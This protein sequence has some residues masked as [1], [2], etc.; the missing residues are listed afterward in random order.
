MGKKEDLSNYLKSLLHRCVEE[1][2]YEFGTP[3]GTGKSHEIA[4]ASVSY[5]PQKFKQILILTIQ[6]KLSREMEENLMRL[7]DPQNGTITQ[8]Q[9]IYIENNQNNFRRACKDGTAVRLIEQMQALIEAYNQKDKQTLRNWLKNPYTQMSSAYA[10]AMEILNNED[11]IQSNSSMEK[12]K[13]EIVQKAEQEYRKAVKQ[14]FSMIRAQE[15]KSDDTF[16]FIKRMVSRCPA[17]EQVYPQINFHEKKVIVT[18]VHKAYDGIDLIFAPS[19]SLKSF[20]NSKDKRLVIFDES[21]QCATALRQSIIDKSLNRNGFASELGKN[22]DGWLHIIS[23]MKLKDE[24]TMKYYDGEIQKGLECFGKRAE[25][26]WKEKMGDTPKFRNIFLRESE[27]KELLYRHG[28]FMVGGSGNVRLSTQ[29]PTVLSYICYKKGDTFLTLAHAS[30]K[31]EL[32]DRY[33][34]VVGLESFIRLCLKIQ[35]SFLYNM[36]FIILKEHF[37]HVEEYERKLRELYQEENSKD[38]MNAP[39]MEQ[40][41]H[42]FFAR[43]VDSNE[44]IFERMMLDYIQSQAYIR[45][46]DE[47][48]KSFLIRDNS[49]YAQGVQLYDEQM[50]DFDKM[51]RVQLQYLDIYTTPEQL[52]VELIRGGNTVILSSATA[53]SKSIIANFDLE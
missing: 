10:T 42:T 33:D 6:N 47:Q 31:D 29:N 38:L 26:L 51:N 49:I 48:N 30:K 43:F 3:T 50:D 36:V 18:S 22:Y 28:V 4:L 9:I 45:V 16:R 8:S 19:V 23:L 11:R 32:T 46:K 24:I 15:Y 52:V 34:T 1:K 2:M 13:S 12:Y 7:C 35:R 39:S 40:S 20:Q 41:V 21:D 53:A 37:L 27:D 14:A 5:F 44:R 25:E 17:L